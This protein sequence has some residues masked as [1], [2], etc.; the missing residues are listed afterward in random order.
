MLTTWG[1]MFIINIVLGALLYCDY[2][3][4][5]TKTHEPFVLTASQSISLRFSCLMTRVCSSR[6]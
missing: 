4:T 1:R 6:S 2:P 5:T 3:M